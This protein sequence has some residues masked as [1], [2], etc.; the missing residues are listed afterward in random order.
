LTV[1]LPIPALLP[2]PRASAAA[3]GQPEAEGPL[4][5]PSLDGLRVLVVDND[6]DARDVLSTVLAQRGAEVLTA[7][8]AAEALGVLERDR[9]DVLVSDI[10][11][12]DEDGYALIAK[13]RAL[14]PERGGRIP[15][16]AL[17]AY[18]GAEDRDQVLAAGFQ[19]HVP[20]P[21]DPVALVQ[22]VAELAAGDR[23]KR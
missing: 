16:A 5:A 8:S 14:P 2:Q 9:L 7:S 12:P 4:A 13:V 6:A 22:V 10:G 11:M 15:A 21:A 3:A 18:A 17:T 1:E 23:D 19:R 20:K